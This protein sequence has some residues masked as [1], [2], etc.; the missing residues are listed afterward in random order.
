[1]RDGESHPATAERQ[2]WTTKMFQEE[3]L[4][5]IAGFHF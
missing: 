5:Y 1:M 2:G 4:H 3:N